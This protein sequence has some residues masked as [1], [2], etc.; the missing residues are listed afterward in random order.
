ME[1][2]DVTDLQLLNHLQENSNYTTK[3][4]AALVNLSQTPVY[5]RLRKLEKEGYVQKYVAIL[6]A[7]KLGRELIVFCDIT[8]KQHTKEIGNRFVKDILSLVEVTECYNIS[9]DYDFR[10]KVLVKNMK[11]YQDFVINSLG[12]VK[13]IGSAH[14]TFVIG[15]IKQTYAVPL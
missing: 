6:D 8:L 4:L 15:T 9:G 12:S 3:E 11:D 7:E 13:N 10:L 2:L 1:N 5:E 14:S